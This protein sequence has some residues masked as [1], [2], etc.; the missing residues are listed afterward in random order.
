[1]NVPAKRL[2][3]PPPK[4]GG[5]ARTYQAGE[6]PPARDAPSP[7][8][9]RGEGATASPTPVVSTSEGTGTQPPAGAHIEDPPS[10][11]LQDILDGKYQLLQRLDEGGMGALFVAHNMALDV[12]VAVK[13]IRADLR[14]GE[15]RTLADRLLQEARAA[16]RLGH[17]AI[18]R[19]MDFGIAPNGDPYLVMELLEGEDLATALDERGKVSPTTAARILLP[20]AHALAAAHEQDIVH[21]DL[22]PENVFLAQSQGGQTQPK[23]ID[24]GIAKMPKR[25]LRRLTVLG[26]AM[27]TPDYMSPEQARGEDVDAQADIWGLCV[28][29]YEMVTAALPFDAPN[30]HAMLRAIIEEEPIPL[31]ELGVDDERFAA[32]VLKGLAKSKAE[33]WQ[34]M[35][36]LGAAL[37]RWLID[38][39]YS[40]DV[41]GAALRAAWLQS[42]SLGYAVDVLSSMPPPPKSA[43]PLLVVVPEREV[44][45]PEEPEPAEARAPAQRR[46]AVSPS[47]PSLWP[48]LLLWLLAL[49]G[50]AA[51]ATGYL[52]IDLPGVPAR[53]PRFW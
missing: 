33:R 20:I 52:G 32:I 22:K 8:A 23:L 12:P 24:F 49:T 15:N 6:E 51:A 50:V 7:P 45:S 21:R 3:P 47:R 30:Q 42:S 18:V 46:A 4:R 37:A 39:G 35:R 9:Q 43:P 19:M 10:V 36:E 34:S 5:S 14:P 25:T 44:A 17:P 2:P 26:D 41:S 48:V 53:L 16:A 31:A 29:L 38:R 1:V 40:D 13:V 27:G 11:D 28:I